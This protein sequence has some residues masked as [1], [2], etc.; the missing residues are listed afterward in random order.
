M[1]LIDAD[2]VIAEIKEVITNREK[3]KTQSNIAKRVF[4]LII[5][6]LEKEPTVE[7]E[8]I[9]RCKDCKHFKHWY[10]DK[11]ICSLWYE[12]GIDVFEDG[13]CSYGAKM[14]GEGEQQ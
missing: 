14:D 7:A 8:P 1:R 9:T 13:F 11:G 12:D 10:R 5:E 3:S 2:I 4:E 6:A